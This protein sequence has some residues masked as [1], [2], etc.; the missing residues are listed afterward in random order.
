MH[1][2][3]N[4]SEHTHHVLLNKSLTISDTKQHTHTHN[5]SFLTH[6]VPVQC[7][8]IPNESGTPHGPCSLRHCWLWGLLLFIAFLLQHLFVTRQKSA[9]VQEFNGSLDTTAGI[10]SSY[11]EREYVG[12][13]SKISKWNMKSTMPYL[14]NASKPLLEKT[15]SLFILASQNCRNS[16]SLFIYRSRSLHGPCCQPETQLAV[17]AAALRPAV[18][19]CLPPAASFR[20]GSNSARHVANVWRRLHMHIATES[21]QQ[22]EVRHSWHPLLMHDSLN[23]QITYPETRL[24]CSV[25]QNSPHIY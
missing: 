2:S 23:L 19:H 7:T 14:Q 21:I 1:D 25:T 22:W 11:M 12:I 3:L 4:I 10:K 18:V 24:S 9:I 20:T 13:A 17:R 5:C 16:P 8:F 6:D 15:H